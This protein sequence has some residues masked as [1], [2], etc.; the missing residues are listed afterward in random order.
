MLL[1]CILKIV[2]FLFP[3]QVQTKTY[4]HQERHIP[5]H[6]QTILKETV[7]IFGCTICNV[8][9]SGQIPVLDSYDFTVRETDETKGKMFFNA[10]KTAIQ[11]WE[12]NIPSHIYTIWTIFGY[13]IQIVYVFY[14]LHL[15]TSRK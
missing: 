9:A 14:I 7:S 6:S 11:T 10:E 8:S 2:Y 4:I 13:I 3:K 15:L 5:I 1:Y 12:Y